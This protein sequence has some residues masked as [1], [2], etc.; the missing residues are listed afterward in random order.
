MIGNPNPKFIAGIT[1]T[2]SYKSFDLSFLFQGSYGNDIYNQNRVYIANMADPNNVSVDA[3]NRWTPT[4]TDTDFPRLVIGDPNA[5]GYT[6]VNVRFSTRY[7][8]DGSY[9]RL[10][11]FTLGYSIPGTALKASGVSLIRVYATGQNLLTFTNYK[12]YDPEVNADPMSNTSVGRDFGVY[13][14]PR[15]FTLGVS[16]TF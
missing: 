8:E 11:N 1:N 6:G 12:G 15:T 7:V 16:V 10:K 9:L 4:H 5:N 3:L 14:Q 2:L 13:P